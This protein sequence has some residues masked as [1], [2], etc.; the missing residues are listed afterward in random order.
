MDRSSDIRLEA[1]EREIKQI[2]QLLERGPDHRNSAPVVITLLT[3]W[4]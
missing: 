1:I 3:I 2:R 4:R